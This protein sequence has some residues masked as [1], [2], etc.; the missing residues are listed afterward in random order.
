VPLNEH[1]AIIGLSPFTVKSLPK[2]E[3]F[4]LLVGAG[5][6]LSATMP[7]GK[8][9]CLK[10]CD[11]NIIQLLGSNRKPILIELVPKLFPTS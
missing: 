6:T 4:D 5:Y 1:P 2:Q 7:S 9:N 10:G 8:H 11:L 3:F